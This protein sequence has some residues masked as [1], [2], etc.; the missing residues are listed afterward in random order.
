MTRWHQL[1][2]RPAL[3]RLN[4]SLTLNGPGLHRFASAPPLTSFGE[5]HVMLL[6]NIQAALGN[7]QG[8]NAMGDDES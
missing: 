5:L 4:H 6:T 8:S 3:P 7:L 1:Q 2:R